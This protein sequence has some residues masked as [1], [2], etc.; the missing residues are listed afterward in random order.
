MTNCE[1]EGFLAV[2]TGPRGVGKD[3]LV[4]HLGIPKVVGHTTR[5]PREGEVNG[6]DYHFVTEELFLAMK[7]R[8]EFV[9]HFCY[10][11]HNGIGL[12]HKG[13]SKQEI[14]RVSNG[15]KIAWR[16]DVTSAVKI[17]EIICNY[18]PS[19]EAARI[20]ARTY[21]FYVGIPNLWV[22]SERLRNRYGGQITTSEIIRLIER[23]WNMWQQYK[24]CFNHVIINETGKLDKTVDKIR[25]IIQDNHK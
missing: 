14:H 5:A 23:D 1:Q 24:D 18:F 17:D 13:T 7:D 19:K 6:I 16:I 9:E 4:D 22:L 21:V 20:L 3:T 10:P 8:N 12:E 25:S 15:E 11:G 2:I